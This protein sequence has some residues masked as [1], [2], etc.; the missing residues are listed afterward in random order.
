M[1]ELESQVR[2]W[3]GHLR[4]SGALGEEELEEL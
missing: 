2:K 1:F 3:R 4:S